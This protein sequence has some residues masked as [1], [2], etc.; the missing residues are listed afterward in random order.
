MSLALEAAAR[1]AHRG[2]SATDNPTEAHAR[3]EAESLVK[4]VLLGDGLPVLGWRDV[5]VNPDVLG[6]SARSAMPTI[7]QVLV[8]R[9]AGSD[10][11]SWERQRYVARREMEHRALARGLEPFDVCSLSCRTVVYR[12]LL[13]GGQLGA[14]FPDLRDPAFDTAIAVFHER[15]ATNTMPRWELA[16]PFRLLAHNG[17]INTLWGNRNAMAMRGPLLDAPAFGPLADR[18]RDPIRPRGSDS[19]S[20]D[21]ALELLV[22][23]G[24]S[25]VH[26]TMM[27]V[28]QAWEKY[29]DVEPAVNAFYEY[30][31]CVLEPWD[32]PAALAY[33]DGVQVAVSLDRNGLR[34]CRYKI[35]ADGM[36]VAG[37]EVGVVDFDP[38]DVVETG[39]RGPGGVF[40]AGGQAGVRAH[41]AHRAS[42]AAP[43]GDACAAHLPGL[44]ERNTRCHVR[45][46]VAA[47]RARGSARLA[48][49]PG[50]SG[51]PQG[52]PA[53]HS[54]RSQGERR[55]RTHSGA[56]GARCGAAASR[57]HRP[58]R[59]RGAGD[60][61]G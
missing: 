43:R 55:A 47:R 11:D 46:A 23:A 53:A 37:F 52:R 14:F 5:P 4:D 42:G 8:G 33:S 54:L 35:R 44:C 24:R 34:P 36:V 2:A 56:A 1:L 51:S 58:A 10:D 50:R 40:L 19:A 7:R 18:V 22:R 15:Y 48:L 20:L 27:L 25:P 49:P 31:Q 29:P 57:A 45:G 41:A 30:H 3:E 26:A 60:R 17:E 6:A 38:R 61:G 16:Q 9:P 28:P 32:G 59:A 21:N 39:K 12:G 13:N